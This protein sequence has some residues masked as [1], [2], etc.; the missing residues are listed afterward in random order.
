MNHS[1]LFV[2]VISRFHY[3]FQVAQK[4]MEEYELNVNSVNHLTKGI[5]KDFKT[6]MT[7]SINATLSHINRRFEKIK[8]SLPHKHRNLKQ[9]LPQ[10]EVFESGIEEEITWSKQA[11]DAL[12]SYENLC[13]TDDVAKEIGRYKVSTRVPCTISLVFIL[14]FM[15]TF[16]LF[17]YA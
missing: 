7:S 11:L 14:I 10:M 4:E 2:E 17:L 13:N 9:I 12:E 1:S 3:F 5:L 8:S 16:F 15:L 6:D